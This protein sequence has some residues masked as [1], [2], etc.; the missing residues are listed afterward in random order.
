VNVT[1]RI[2]VL[3]RFLRIAA[4]AARRGSRYSPLVY[5]YAFGL[6]VLILVGLLALGLQMPI[7]WSAYFLWI[8]LIGVLAL[9]LQLII[10]AMNRRQKSDLR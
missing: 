1:P 2:T 8:G 3:W 5:I 4:V 7:P 10:R 6:T 9:A